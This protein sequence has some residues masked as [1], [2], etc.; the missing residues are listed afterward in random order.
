MLIAHEDGILREASLVTVLIVLE[1]RQPVHKE[2]SGG[3]KV[4][5]LAWQNLRS[6][7]TRGFQ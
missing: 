7:S 5:E 6:I 3:R 1:A 2:G 4:G